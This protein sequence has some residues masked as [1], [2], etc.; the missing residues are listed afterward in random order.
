M[1]PSRDHL[2]R[3]GEFACEDAYHLLVRL[4]DNSKD[5]DA[6]EAIAQLICDSEARGY[7]RGADDQRRRPNVHVEQVVLAGE[8]LREGRL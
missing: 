5:E 6:I 1:K 8:A 2:Q 3:A 7:C 4:C